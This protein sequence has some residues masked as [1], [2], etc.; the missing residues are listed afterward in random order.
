MS[1]DDF[2]LVVEVHLIG[3]ATCTKAVWQL[4]RT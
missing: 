1:L 4:M 2:R 3:G